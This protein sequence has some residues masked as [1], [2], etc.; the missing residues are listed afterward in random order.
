MTIPSFLLLPFLFAVIGKHREGK[1]EWKDESGDG[2]LMNSDVDV[3]A[4]YKPQ[5]GET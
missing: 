2:S 4:I 3:H 1:G 5:T